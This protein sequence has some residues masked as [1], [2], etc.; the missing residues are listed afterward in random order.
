MNYTEISIA[1]TREERKLFAKIQK[2]PEPITKEN[3][4][5][6][7]RLINLGIA[8][9][10]IVMINGKGNLKDR[11]IAPDETHGRNFYNFDLGRRSTERW[12]CIRS[13]IA[14]AISIAAIIFS[15]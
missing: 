14:V 10:V 6:C 5:I 7:N 2:K 12:N 13:W 1:L 9:E 8:Q 3:R 15:A 4:A 11:A